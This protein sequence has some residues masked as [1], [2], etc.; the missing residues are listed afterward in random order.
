MPAKGFQIIGIETK[1]HRKSAPQKQVRIDHNTN[2]TS[3]R[4]KTKTDL[5]VEIR[6]TVSYGILGIVQ[7]DCEIAY[8]DENK[9]EITK[10]ELKWEK[11]HKLPDNIAENV[12]NRV[13]AQGSF[14]VLNIAK[15]L[16]LP[17]PFKIEIPQIKIGKKGEM[18][19][20]KNNSPEIA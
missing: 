20:S 15:K 11:E 4:K 10:A 19:S 14:E 9:D 12:H 6:Y 8:H 1:R 18:P 13:L 5:A 2:I 3:V 16:N 7:L 17:P